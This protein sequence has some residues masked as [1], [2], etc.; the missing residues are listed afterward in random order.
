MFCSKCGCQLPEG[1]AFCTQCGNR[2]GDVEEKRENGAFEQEQY[3]NT[4]NDSTT[5]N[6]PHCG[7]VMY[8]MLDTCPHCHGPVLSEE[9][10]LQQRIEQEEYDAQWKKEQEE[11]YKRIKRNELACFFACIVI[12]VLAAVFA[13]MLYEGDVNFEFIFALFVTAYAVTSFIYGIHRLHPIRRFPS[14]WKIPIIGQGIVLTVAF[15]VGY[16]GGMVYWVPTSLIKIV[17]GKSI[18]SDKTIDWLLKKDLID[19]IDPAD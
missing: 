10:L 11:D 1:S 5:M 19:P 18:L 2:L 17:T 7:G 16:P 15:V 9:L 14:I 8:K 12:G 6:C 4:S 13:G 3:R